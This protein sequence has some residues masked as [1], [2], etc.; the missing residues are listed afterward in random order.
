V[1]K[2]RSDLDGAEVMH[3]KALEINEKLGCLE[4][5]ADQY[6][7]LGIVLKQRGDLDGARKLWTKARDLYQKIGMPHKVEEIQGWLDETDES[8]QA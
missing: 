2:Q 3:R 6:G 7:N 4:G 1:L 5:I 8:K